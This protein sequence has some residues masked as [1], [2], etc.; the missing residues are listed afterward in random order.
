M[1]TK[2]KY[3]FEI[4]PIVP[5]DFDGAVGVCNQ[6]TAAIAY[7]KELRR[8]SSWTDECHMAQAMLPKWQQAQV[9]AQKVVHSYQMKLDF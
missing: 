3:E 2:S 6:A 1:A 7:W 4:V 8:Y 9:T 5:E